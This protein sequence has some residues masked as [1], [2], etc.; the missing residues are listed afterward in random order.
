ML[1]IQVL[2]RVTNTGTRTCDKYAQ[3]Q[4][5]SFLSTGVM[6][7]NGRTYEESFLVAG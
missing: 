4:K 7:D 2:V 5:I 3:Q 6:V 1:Q